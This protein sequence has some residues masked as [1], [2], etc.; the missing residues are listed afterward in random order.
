M[1]SQKGVTLL[2][3]LI[4][5]SLVAMLSTAMLFAMRTS[6]LVYQRT[7]QRMEENRRVVGIE[8][9]VTSQLGGVM[10]AVRMCTIE[11]GPPGRTSFFAG[12]S[13]ILRLVSSYSIAEGARG[14]P[15][16]IEYRV[17]PSSSGQ[18]RLVATESAYTGPLST[19]PYCTDPLPAD[20][21][22][23]ALLPAPPNTA[24]FV[25]ADHLA[26]CRISYHQPYNINLFNESPWMP[27]WTRPDLPAAVR[28]EMRP[29]ELV[30]GSLPPLDIT[31]PI[32]VT[33]DPFT[34]YQDRLQ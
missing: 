24:T 7:A 6:V 15:R 3:L 12:N 32:R 23:T 25:L 2:E 27:L 28:L 16:I 9:I 19:G 29:A 5:V 33:R 11:D 17:L 14:Y 22:S 4:A 31:A 1:R 34:L 8:R 20:P 18:F 30:P 21:E 13:G 10:A 26:Y